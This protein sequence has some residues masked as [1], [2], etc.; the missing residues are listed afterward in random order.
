MWSRCAPLVIVPRTRSE[1]S[2]FSSADAKYIAL[3]LVTLVDFS[4]VH[5][6][7][8]EYAIFCRKTIL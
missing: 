4:S 8:Y 6:T 1:D 7:A 2:R 3:T 5:V